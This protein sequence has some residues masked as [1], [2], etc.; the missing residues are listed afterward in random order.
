MSFAM[1]K[2][3]RPKDKNAPKR[4]ASSYVIFGKENRTRIKNENP[5]F[6][7]TEMMKKISE[8]WRNLNEN[9][10]ISYKAKYDESKAK[11]VEAMVKYKNSDSYRAFQV[12]LTEW[13]E[14]QEEMGNNK[15]NR[16]LKAN[17]DRKKT[18]NKSKNNGIKSKIN[19]FFDR[20]RDR[21][22]KSK[23]P[24]EAVSNQYGWGLAKGSEYITRMMKTDMEGA[25]FAAICLAKFRANIEMMDFSFGGPHFEIGL[26]ME[27]V[28]RIIKKQSSQSTMK[29][30]YETLV[31][32]H[33]TWDEYCLADDIKVVID[34]M[35]TK[36]AF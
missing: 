28:E 29:P 26:F 14:L 23:H 31:K 27:C 12:K 30:L 6:K 7:P 19:S 17:G 20:Y 10:K 16:N 15:E 1:K 36:W 34:K 25:T 18:K 2:S 33:Q 32:Y 22:R 35:K 4:P 24:R 13:K 21:L 3:K 5:E 8:E 9:E 11:Y